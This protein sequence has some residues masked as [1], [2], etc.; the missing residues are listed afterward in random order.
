M[1]TIGCMNMKGI[2]R[3]LKLKEIDVFYYSIDEE[4]SYSNDVH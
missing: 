3:P 2:I 1:D 4:F